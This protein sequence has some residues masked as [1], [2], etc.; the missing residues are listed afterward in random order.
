MIFLAKF[1]SLLGK[2]KVGFLVQKIQR[3]I[4]VYPKIYRD[5]RT[6]R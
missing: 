1:I 5:F 3:K 2:Q 4:P 6:E